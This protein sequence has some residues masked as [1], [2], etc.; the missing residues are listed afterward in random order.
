MCC[1]TR[2]VTTPKTGQVPS[3]L[4]VQ[5]VVVGVVETLVTFTHAAKGSTL[6][7]LWAFRISLMLW[8]IPKLVRYM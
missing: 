6:G 3:Q 7:G 2:E 1:A 4:E 8:P 5:G